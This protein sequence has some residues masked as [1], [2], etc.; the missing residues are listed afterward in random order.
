VRVPIIAPPF[1]KTMYGVLEARV[2]TKPL[3]FLE[4]VSHAGAGRG[5]RPREGD[6]HDNGHPGARRLVANRCRRGLELDERTALP[7]Q[8][9][10]WLTASMPCGSC[11]G[12]AALGF[13][14]LPTACTSLAI[15][16]WPSSLPLGS[17]V[18][19]DAEQ[20]QPIFE[21]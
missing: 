11:N 15:G 5:W 13:I 21:Y 16:A 6:V 9:C 7:D 12:N 3:P 4:V 10:C 2:L 20:N 14:S 19:A 17:L 8:M 18:Q 1:D